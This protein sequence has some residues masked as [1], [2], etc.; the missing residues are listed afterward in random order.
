MSPE[1]R[2]A[3]GAWMEQALAL[4]ALGEGTTSPNPQVGCVV[5]RNGEAV[6]AGWHRAAGEPHAEVTALDAAGERARGATLYVTL[7]PCS[8]HGRTPPCADRIVA[9]GVARV[10]AAIQDPNPFVDGGGF[11]RLRAAGIAVETGLGADFAETIN[12]A[13]LRSHRSARPF[14]TLKAGVSADGMIAAQGGRSRWITGPAARRFAHRLRYRH[15]AV[16][17]GAGTLRRDD[18]GLDVRLAGVAVARVRAVIAAEGDVPESARLLAGPPEPRPVVY[19]ASTRAD[20]ASARLGARAR[21]VGVP[22]AEGRLDLHAVLA[23]LH[24][25]G[26]RSVLV[27]GGGATLGSFLAA[28]LADA[29][30]LFVAPIVLGARGGTPLFDLRTAEDPARAHRLTGVRRLRVGADWAYL[31]RLGGEGCSPA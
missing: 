27:E 4:A 5:V 25:R 16:L 3:D 15:D 10:V 23:D 7:E 24:A 6:G 17:V 21:V 26:C 30:A 9:S 2:R 28:G 29:V 19:A 18:P 14:V 31:G 20:T 13:F 1:D 12:A 11:A 8:H 22:A